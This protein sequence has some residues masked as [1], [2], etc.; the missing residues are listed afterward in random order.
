MK[1]LVVEEAE[2]SLFLEG[3]VAVA[4]MGGGD[5]EDESERATA[6]AAADFL[7]LATA[8]A[9]MPHSAMTELYGMVKSANPS[10][11]RPN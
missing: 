10:A 9:L 2:D 3:V 7:P 8:A 4:G 11:K 1:L 5:D 6:T